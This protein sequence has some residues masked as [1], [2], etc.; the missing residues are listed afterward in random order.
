M[1]VTKKFYWSLE[2]LCLVWMAYHAHVP[3]TQVAKILQRSYT[4]VHKTEVTPEGR[5][6]IRKK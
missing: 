1:Q 2:E 6:N 3:V 5:T 4:S